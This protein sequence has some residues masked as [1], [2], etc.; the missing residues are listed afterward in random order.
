MDEVCEFYDDMLARRHD[1]NYEADGVVVKVDSLSQQNSLGFAGREPR[2]AIAY[3][4]P[5]E[6]ATT[7][8]VAHRLS[9]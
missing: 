6:R 4:F 3:K 5:A 8:P 2:W 7:P 1:W 9:T